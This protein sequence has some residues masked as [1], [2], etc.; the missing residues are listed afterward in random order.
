[1]TFG[2]PRHRGANG[3]PEC[4]VAVKRL[5]GAVN[6]EFRE[7]DGLIQALAASL[8]HWRHS[9]LSGRQR[10][11]PPGPFQSRPD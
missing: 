7:H 5:F 11:K 6:Q 9:S 1:M 3:G 10:A 8:S 4:S 2:R